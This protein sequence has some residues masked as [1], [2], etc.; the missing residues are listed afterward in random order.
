MRWT[1]IRLSR[2]IRETPSSVSPVSG[3]VEIKVTAQVHSTN[4]LYN[5][6][7]QSAGGGVPVRSSWNFS[8]TNAAWIS[9]L[10]GHIFYFSDSTTKTVR[11]SELS[12]L[13]KLRACQCFLPSHRE[14]SV[15]ARIF[16]HGLGRS[17]KVWLLRPAQPARQQTEGLVKKPWR[18]TWVVW[19]WY[20]APSASV[21]LLFHY[22]QLWRGSCLPHSLKHNMKDHRFQP[23]VFFFP[24]H[25]HC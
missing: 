3:A 17:D 4:L 21:A 8:G 1:H 25:F 19:R 5:V 12:E 23:R 10:P 6:L 15:E 24:L 11:H 18:Q 14:I 20:I 16:W 7:H 22:F 2:Q 9:G 13:F